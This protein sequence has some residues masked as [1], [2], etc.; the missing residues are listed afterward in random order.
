VIQ[1]EIIKS[2]KPP[3]GSG[4]ININLKILLGREINKINS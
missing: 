1:K 2:K 3:L 4:E